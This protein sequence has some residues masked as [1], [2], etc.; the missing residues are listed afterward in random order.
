VREVSVRK[1]CES[2]CI[3]PLHCAAVNPDTRALEALFRVVPDVHVVDADQR[4]L[5][6][7]A[8]ACAGDG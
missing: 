1:K 7:Y 2:A 3:T 5:V 6:H 8:A 4:K